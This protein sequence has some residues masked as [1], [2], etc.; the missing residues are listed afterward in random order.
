MEAKQEVLEYAQDKA[1]ELKTAVIIVELVCHDNSNGFF[2]ITQETE[3][4]TFK[5][6]REHAEVSKVI[7][8]ERFIPSCWN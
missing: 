1:N 6:F 8:H 4:A 3:E 7:K 5:A 2:L